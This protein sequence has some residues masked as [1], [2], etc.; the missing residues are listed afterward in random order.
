MGSHFGGGDLSY[1]K[2]SEAKAMGGFIEDLGVPYSALILEEHSRTT[3]QNAS[4]TS[5]LL[6]VKKINHILLVTSALHMER[7]K[8]LF[9][10]QGLQVEAIATDHEATLRPLGALAYLPNADA[11]SNSA[12]A[13]KECAGRVAWSMGVK[14]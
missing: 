9:E 1:A 12:R 3:S 6:K 10:N 13:I 14:R 11:L 5:E 7:A 8:H 2:E 4:M